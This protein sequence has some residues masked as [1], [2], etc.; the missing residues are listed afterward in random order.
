[1][2]IAPRAG[3]RSE[4]ASRGTRIWYKDWGSGQP[5]VFS[6][7]WPLCGDAWDDQMLFL[8][9]HGYRTI[10]HD[11][12]GHGRSDQPSGGNDMNTYADDLATLIEALDLRDVVLIS[13][14]PPL[15]LRTE[16]NPTV[17]RPRR[18][19]KFAAAC[20]PTGRNI[21]GC[22]RAVFR[23]QPAWRRCPQG[24]KDDF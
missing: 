24:I 1:M 20:S 15:M 12:R 22:C 9:A 23:R 19:T 4:I 21:T 7:D 11:R 8:S 13:A 10:A 16:A 5:I 17:C 3:R 18:S 6:H 2:P 14:I